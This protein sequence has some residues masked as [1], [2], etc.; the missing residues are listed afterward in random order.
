MRRSR[1]CLCF[2]FASGLL[3]HMAGGTA[4]H[5][6][7]GGVPAQVRN[8][9]ENIGVQ[10]AASGC[11]EVAIPSP[12]NTDVSRAVM[13]AGPEPSGKK[14]SV[15]SRCARGDGWDSMCG[16]W[17]TPRFHMLPPKGGLRCWDGRGLNHLVGRVGDSARDRLGMP[18][19]LIAMSTSLSRM[20]S[21]VLNPA[22]I[23]F[24]MKPQGPLE[25]LQQW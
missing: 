9:G 5:S 8:V 16:D 13:G 4:L 17:C 20:R 22:A 25:H 6:G 10:V 3:I 15:A 7:D 1:V 21:L 11:A 23:D 24:P 18:S 14:V 19:A 12:R 2:L